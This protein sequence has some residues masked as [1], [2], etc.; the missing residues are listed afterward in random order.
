[1]RAYAANHAQDFLRFRSTIA[2]D[3]LADIRRYAR[4]INRH[5]L[6][7]G[8]NS[9]NSSDVLFSQC[10]TYGYN[11]YEMSQAEDFVVVEDMSSQPRTLPNGQVIE[12]GPT[13]EQLHAIS[14]RKP[15]VA[16]TLADADYHTPPNLVRLALA[17]AAAHGAS[18]LW[19]PTWPE[20]E[21]QEMVSTIRPQ[22]DFL[23]R[24]A[25]L[26]NEAQPREDVILF[27]PFRKWIA[28]NQCVASRLATA[29]T[30]VNAQYSVMCED[31]FASPAFKMAAQR[32]TRVLLAETLA[33]FTKDEMNTVNAF[34]QAGGVVVTADHT[35]W[36]KEVRGRIGTPSIE[37]EGPP[38]LRAVMC[39]QPKRTIVH[40]LNM[41]IQR[42][43][44][45]EDSATPATN[46]L[47]TCRVP[48]K[49]TGSVN[50]LTAD[51]HSASGPLMFRTKPA[52]EQMLVQVRVPSVYV[53]MLIV[54]EP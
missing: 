9:L 12:Y 40:L 29:L 47:V 39:D 3:F 34:R 35:N 27:L 8:N 50:A 10:R 6:I 11:I 2:R 41:N 53:S 14:H 46:V 16:V 54:I 31:D 42:R 43:S 49:K 7:T 33:D 25:R 22:A 15:I 18:Y 23:R 5:A 45:F 4:T 28:T 48:L 1:M 32:G 20:K 13:Y 38:T 36:L 37:L 24:N 44:S 26:L 21:R 52:G 30:R 51:S 19:W 17:E